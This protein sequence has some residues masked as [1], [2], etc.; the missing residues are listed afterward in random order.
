MSAESEKQCSTARASSWAEEPASRFAVT[1]AVLIGVCLAAPVSGV[2]AKSVGSDHEASKNGPRH[3]SLGC[4]KGPGIASCYTM[5]LVVRGS[6]TIRGTG[7]RTEQSKCGGVLSAIAGGGTEV[8]LPVLSVN[9]GKAQFTAALEGWK[10]PGTYK[11]HTA[12]SKS[13]VAVSGSGGG[14]T[15]GNLEYQ[16][17]VAGAKKQASVTATIGQNGAVHISFANLAATNQPTK[18]VSGQATYTCQNT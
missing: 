4:F 5:T 8:L 13:F 2:L 9:G 17:S 18:T 3:A 14:L 10:G 16:A 6:Q 1:V 11:L 15:V 7:Y 12:Q